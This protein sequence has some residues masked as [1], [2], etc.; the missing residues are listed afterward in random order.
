MFPFIKF[1]IILFGIIYLIRWV[2]KGLFRVFVGKLVEQAQNGGFQSKTYTNGA[3]QKTAEPKSSPLDA[4]KL[5][6]DYID[7]E[8]VK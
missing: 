1:I 2:F 3:Q 4:D 6:G 5:G 7:Y 8:E